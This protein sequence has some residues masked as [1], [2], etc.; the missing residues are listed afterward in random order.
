M[1]WWYVNN[2]NFSGIAKIARKWLCV[3]ATST[4]SERVFS[5][6]GLVV[7]AKRSRLSGFALRDQV[8]IRRNLRYIEC[9]EDE[10]IKALKDS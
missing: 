2:V 7:T 1:S 8:L 3:S 5:D 4:A 6:C 10:I 9:N